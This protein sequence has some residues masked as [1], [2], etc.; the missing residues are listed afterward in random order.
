MIYYAASLA[1]CAA[2]MAFAI[3]ILRRSRSRAISILM[4]YLMLETAIELACLFASSLTYARVYFILAVPEY[5]LMGVVSLSLAYMLL[6]SR[7]GVVLRLGPFAIAGPLFFSLVLMLPLV[8]ALAL[9]LNELAHI[10]SLALVLGSL[11]R[12]EEA[13]P[14]W[15]AKVAWGWVLLLLLLIAAVETLLRFGNHQLTN[16]AVPVAWTIGLGALLRSMRCRELEQ[17]S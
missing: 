16:Y 1:L 13:A 9:R 5:L 15:V 10:L 7:R 8:F 6:P 2:D 12:Q 3:L 11:L 17:T 4:I 14:P